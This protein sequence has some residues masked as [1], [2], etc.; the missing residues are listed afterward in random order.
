MSTN[1]EGP[2]RRLRRSIITSISVAAALL[3]AGCGGGTAVIDHGAGPPNTLS[4][5]ER[6]AGWMLL[7]DGVSL[8]GWRGLGRQDI[9]EGHW[10][11][12]DGAIRKVASGEVPTADDGQPLEGGDLLTE[13]TYEDFEL[14]FEWKVAPGAN[15]GVKYNVSEAYSTA[16][17]PEYAALGF[18]YQVLDDDKHPDAMNGRHRT[19]GALYDMIPPNQLKQLQPVGE[20]NAARIVFVDG[21]GEHWLNGTKIVEYDLATPRFDALLGDSKYTVYEN[22]ADRRDGHIVL[23]DH[24]DDV[25]FRNIKI[26]PR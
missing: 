17:E 13:D 25:W 24:G 7:F 9:P 5:S 4:Q 6:E 20:Y 21:H 15:G 12:E 26:R 22:F 14:Y 1:R 19:A 23:Q 10:R 18:E 2:A 11:V 3:L 8:D 16:H